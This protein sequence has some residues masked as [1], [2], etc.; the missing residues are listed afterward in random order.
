[1]K[2]ILRNINIGLTAPRMIL[3]DV[4]EIRTSKKNT[5]ATTAISLKEE[6]MKILILVISIAAIF[7]RGSSL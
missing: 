7:A 1:M 3:T 4:D 5:R 6:E 2:I